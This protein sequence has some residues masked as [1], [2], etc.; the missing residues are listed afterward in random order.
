MKKLLSAFLLTCAIE[1]WAS[2]GT[3]ELS[4]QTPGYYCNL[5]IA[6]YTYDSDG[7]GAWAYDQPFYDSQVIYIFHSVAALKVKN[8]CGQS[9]NRE[10]WRS[11]EYD[12]SS[13]QKLCIS[14]RGDTYLYN[15][16]TNASC[17]ANAKDC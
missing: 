1:A 9:V 16:L 10:F 17:V 11:G 8:L 7:E 2:H 4:V 6:T 3:I 13:T 14:V 12:C 5:G 15:I